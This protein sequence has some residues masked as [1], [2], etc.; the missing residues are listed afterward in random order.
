MEKFCHLH[1]HSF[2]SKLDGIPSPE[3]YVAKAKEKQHPY[4]SITDHGHANSFFRLQTS[5]HESGIKPI[6]GIEMYIN[7]YLVTTS[8]KEKRIRTRDRHLILLAK[9]KIGYENLLYLNY[10]SMKDA[11]HFYYSPRITTQELFNNKEGL[12]VGSACINSPFGGLLMNGE[13]LETFNLVKKF[14]EELGEDFYIEVQLNELNYAFEKLKN[15]QKTYNDT[16]ISIANKLGIPIV[17][18]GDVHYLEKG[19]DNLQT[20]SIIIRNKETIESNTFELESKNLYYHS[21]ADYIGFDKDFGYNYGE[22]RV[23]SYCNNAVDIASRINFEMPI[24]K[25]M[26][27]PKITEDDNK[28]LILK[29]KEGLIRKLKKESYTEVPQEYRKRLEYELEVLIRKGFA[30]YFL[31]FEDIY[32]FIKREGILRGVSRGSGGGCL[33]LYALDVT[34]IDPIKYGLIFSRFLSTERTSDIVINYFKE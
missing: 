10:L 32:E 14:Q 17:I 8:E 18:T 9:N 3:E 22:E 21:I 25:K 34:T 26:H 23:T 2:F 31:I 20:L 24:R 15:G 27:L 16:M 7:D 11:D 5:C 33:T 6:F 30:G 13:V 1:L 12:I 4:L 19:Q 28:V 29:S